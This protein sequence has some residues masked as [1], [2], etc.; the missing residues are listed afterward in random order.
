MINDIKLYYKNKI[1]PL[2]YE[3]FTVKQLKPQTMKSL[4]HQVNM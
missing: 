2:N 3:I 1:S 4:N